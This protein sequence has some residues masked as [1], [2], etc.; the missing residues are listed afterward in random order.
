MNPFV[1]TYLKF[2]K[3]PAPGHTTTLSLASKILTE[4]DE[5]ARAQPY[6][7]G[8][9]EAVDDPGIHNI[10]LA[11][12]YGSGK[13][14]ILKT[15]QSQNPQHRYL[16]I[17]LAS[18]TEA[19][20]GPQQEVPQNGNQGLKAADMERQ[21]EISILQQIFYHVHPFDIPDSRFKRIINI[22]P[23]RI[24]AISFGLI[25]WVTSVL[26]LFKA[27]Y[28]R[29]LDPSGWDFA[30]QLNG[31]AVVAILLFLAG[32]GLFARAA[33]RLFT[34][35]KINKFNIKGELELG[36]NTDKSVF[37]QHL[38]EILYFFER[39]DYNVVVFEDL[40]RFDNTQIFT[41]LR[42]INTLLNTSMPINRPVSFIYAI[43]DEVFRD[44]SERVK[45]F[46]MIIPVIPFIDP[47]NAGDQIRKLV[48]R[49]DIVG[50]LSEDFLEDVV[51]F[52]DDIDMRLLINI[53]QEYLIY[54]KSLSEDLPQDNLFAMVTYKN[55]FP[56]D[57]G[58]LH[59]RKGKLFDFIASKPTY[60]AQL[61]KSL[62]TDIAK[63]EEQ[64]E[65]IGQEPLR[66]LKELRSLYVLQYFAKADTE[67]IYVDGRKMPFDE[68]VEEE[69]FDKLIKEHFH[70]YVIYQHG[71][72]V[73]YNPVPSQ[74]INV[75]FRDIEKAVSPYTYAQR[76][77]FIE[78]KAALRLSGTAKALQEL[79]ARRSEIE[80]LSLKGIFERVEGEAFLKPFENDLLVRNLLLN[81]YL[82]EHY[83]DY[84]SLFHGESKED[85]TFLRSVKSGVTSAFDYKLDYAGHVARKL[86]QKYYNRDAVL[87]YDL[88][89]FLASEYE[90]Y[91]SQYD[92]VID[93]LGSATGD[94]LDFIDGYL[95]KRQ[96]YQALFIKTLCHRWPGFWDALKA[97]HQ[98]AQTLSAY[99]KHILTHADNGDIV[100]FAQD[101]DIG[102]FMERQP[103]FLEIASGCDPRK[104]ESLI[105]SLSLKLEV[106][107]A[108]SQAT[109]ALFDF[110]YAQGAYRI[111]PGNIATI[112][113]DKDPDATAELLRQLNYTT[114]QQSHC[115]TLIQ[116]LQ[117]NLAEYA[118][119]VLLDPQ[120]SK[121][122][123]ASIIALLNNEALDESWKAAFAK[124]Q[125]QVVNTLTEIHS[126]EVMALLLQ[127]GKAAASWGNAE[128]YYRTCGEEAFDATLAAFLNRPEVYNSLKS[129]APEQNIDAPEAARFIEQLF[130]CDALSEA[131]YRGLCSA[132][133][134][135][136]DQLAVE[137]LS[138]EKV[139]FL[140]EDRALN[141]TVVNYE[142]LREY[143]SN[144]RL[145]VSL[146][147]EHQDAFAAGF[148]QYTIERAEVVALLRS[149]GFSGGNKV[150]LLDYISESLITN[151]P[152][153]AR[154]G[155]EAAADTGYKVRS[156]EVLKSFFSHSPSVAKRITVL[157]T[158]RD[159]FQD[160]EV[161]HVL[162][163]LGEPY[164]QLFVYRKKPAF[165]NTPYHR[166]LFDYLKRRKMI[167]TWDVKEKEPEKIRVVANYS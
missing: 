34:N 1:A 167:S 125:V 133:G 32:V 118:N 4:A 158:S 50:V 127:E 15:F 139:N 90:V 146:A 123:E 120:N 10:A 119:N 134:T 76:K 83:S 78:E 51:T 44:K 65:L 19:N 97:R 36:D 62:D 138:V 72:V 66:N 25:L 109:R 85:Y 142:R 53:F 42:E 8:L 157:N 144:P 98:G 68:L 101:G 153:V 132:S 71:H 104:M 156:F 47:V 45:F 114:V 154:A 7:D 18:F 159:N 27:N 74:S 95:E 61:M 141:L 164:V 39:T 40:D 91:K 9:R 46:E 160:W 22:K 124:Q 88:M 48:R 29:Y 59:K 103:D 151:N 143:F 131:A 12:T 11:G 6:L 79:R 105:S 52:I 129:S 162:E 155:C 121:E 84:I 137:R 111:T 86:A 54:R 31:Y 41:K 82:N 150:K 77:E 23:E 102:N 17:S 56:E 166:Q 163:M 43:R 135:A 113:L 57:F 165:D 2:R 58:K 3:K 136:W 16:N 70:T 152:D 75:S 92:A 107:P 108:P 49:A 110:V 55:L 130:L 94:P 73:N 149:E 122:S 116:N 60:V 145:H 81:G 24:Q 5:L 106:L 148:E 33:V 112:V 64:L 67:A 63:L 14:T 28:I 89:D 96:E 38:E 147:E 80:H 13:S 30:K 140:V 115:E 128:V 87:N 26:V 99:L 20:A 37:N 161:Q 117:A 21:L 93:R 69:N 100:L 35:S 126:K